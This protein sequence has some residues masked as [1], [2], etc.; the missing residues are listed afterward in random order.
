MAALTIN[1]PQGRP[2]V[3]AHCFI[4][5]L[6]AAAS[7]SCSTS[8]QHYTGAVPSGYY[9]HDGVKIH[10]K[11]VGRGRAV[12]FL[13]GF[14]MSLDTWRFVVESLGDEYRL[15]LVDLKGHGLSDRPRD[16][17]YAAKDHA[18]VVRGLID[19]LG[20]ENVVVVGHSFGAV[21][22]LAA[23][24]DAQRHGSSEIIATLV[25]IA[26]SVDAENIPLFLRLLRTPVLG[27]LGLKLTSASLRTRLMLKR[28]Y[29]DA[30]KITDSLVELYARHQSVPGTDYAFIKT[31][32]QLVPIDIAQ[33]KR[34][35]SKLDIPVINIWGEHDEIISRA[36]AK[37]VCQLVPRCELVTI[38]R[39]GHIPQEESPEKVV[40]L[41]RDFLRRN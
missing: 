16:G 34:D 25:L 18:R 41:L 35:L 5:I 30:S 12:V 20:L 24:L 13:H 36:A 17:M 29:Y 7:T 23:A 8:L 9:L 33:S 32:E 14:G 31:A 26:G 38:Q 15:V 6:L 37:S 27:W 11:Q 19:Y 10:F 22:G 39:T 1:M 4:S 28:A 3:K 2:R 40:S 21:V